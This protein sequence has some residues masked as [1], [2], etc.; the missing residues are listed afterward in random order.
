M[1]EVAARLD[2]EKEVV[3]DPRSP[4]AECRRGRHPVEGDV[5]LD[6]IE[7][8][9]VVLELRSTG[10]RWVESMPPVLVDEPGRTDPDGHSCS[11]PAARSGSKCLEL[12]ALAGLSGSV[13]GFVSLAMAFRSLT[14]ARDRTRA[15]HGR[16]LGRDGRH[17]DVLGAN[18]TRDGLG[19]AFRQASD[20]CT[21]IG[22]AISGFIIA[23]RSDVVSAVVHEW[24]V[25]RV[26]ARQRF[27]G[28]SS[29]IGG[30]AACAE[31]A[32]IGPVNAPMKRQDE[33]PRYGSTHIAMLVG[34][35]RRAPTSPAAHTRPS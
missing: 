17:A 16:G 19:R 29:D 6:R 31:E 30:L 15:P 26:R 5:E 27:R 20:V 11:W 32:T 35:A 8:A 33:W 25:Q 2:R 21:G 4:R 12:A 13:G 1:G 34:P 22:F 18:A 24:K 3:R 14:V 9:G 23:R 7:R 10:R 28:A